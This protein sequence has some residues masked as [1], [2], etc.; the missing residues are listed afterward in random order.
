MNGD[1]YGGNRSET[2]FDSVYKFSKTGPWINL[3]DSSKFPNNAGV[4]NRWAGRSLACMYSRSIH[5]THSL[6]TMHESLTYHA[7]SKV[8]SAVCRVSSSS[9]AP[10]RCI[11][12]L[13]RPKYWP[14]ESDASGRG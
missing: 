5:R 2:V 7:F 3:F 6:T 9:D 10:C 14:K 4:R 8:S 1:M 11:R 13:F 12:S